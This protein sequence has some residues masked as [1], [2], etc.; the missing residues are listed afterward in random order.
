MA[1]LANMSLF[2]TRV[3][4]LE[5]RVPGSVDPGTQVHVPGYPGPGGTLPPTRVPGFVR[6]C[7]GDKCAHMGRRDL[8]AHQHMCAH[9]CAHMCWCAHIRKPMCGSVGDPGS[10]IH[11][12]RSRDEHATRV[13]IFACAGSAHAHGSAH[14]VYMVAH[15][16]HT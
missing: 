10:A 12:F 13:R 5:R 14:N 1:S 15:C 7:A 8:Y 6:I 3:P 2:T 16:A 9:V 11:P 4:G